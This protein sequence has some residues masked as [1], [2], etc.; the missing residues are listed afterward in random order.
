MFLLHISIHHGGKRSTLILDS[1]LVACKDR[2]KMVN[3]PVQTVGASAKVTEGFVV[4]SCMVC[5]TLFRRGAVHGGCHVAD[6]GRQSATHIPVLQ[7]REVR[8]LMCTRIQHGM[9][10]PTNRVP[11]VANGLFLLGGIKWWQ[12]FDS[13]LTL[14]LRR[15]RVSHIQARITCVAGSATIG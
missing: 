11:C 14:R 9:A 13:Q 15:R 10:R 6:C 1:L 8:D 2:L 7:V 5:H 3:L 12:C 4:C